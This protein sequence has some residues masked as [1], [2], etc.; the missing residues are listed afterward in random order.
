MLLSLKLENLILIEKAVVRFEDGFHIITGETGS[1][2]SILLTAIRLILG[3]KGG[4]DLIRSQ[5]P[6][7]IIEAEFSSFPNPMPEGIDAPRPG[8]PLLIRREILPSG[9]SRCFVQDQLVSIAI[10]RKITESL[11]EIVDQSSSHLLVSSESQRLMLDTFANLREQASFFA[12]SFAEEKRLRKQLENALLAN[13]NQ[14]RDLE[15]AESGLQY[16]ENVQWK[17]DEELLLEEQHRLLA[18]AQELIEKTAQVADGLS[19]LAPQMKQ[20]NHILETAAK[21]DPSLKEIAQSI[22]SSTI[23]LEEAESSL[24]AYLNR[25]ETA[26]EHLAAIESRLSLI[27]QIKRRFG[28]SWEAVEKQKGKFFRQIEELHALEGQIDTLKTALFDIEKTNQN[29]AEQ[30]SCQRQTAAQ[31]LSA[32]VLKELQDLNLPLAQFEIS[33]RRIEMT[34]GG[35]DLV[36]FLFSANPGLSPVPL[37]QAAS[38]GELSRLVLALKTALAEQNDC[39]CLI[40]DEIDSNVGGQTAVALGEK[41]RAIAKN[42]QVIAVTHFVQVAKAALHHFSV[43][44]VEKN[45]SFITKVERLSKALREKEYARMLG[46]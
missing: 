23:E 44:K 31:I 19:T 6:C 33:V 8:D 22:K 42:A 28:N 11:V 34:F 37:E 9:K 29:L 43:C 36:R 41:L 1:G 30:I 40:F 46:D 15:W 18:N 7:A 25:K 13:A 39:K 20:L 14:S 35:I 38:G 16:I 17:K 21:I 27:D 26:P 3:E 24:Q 5:A 10:L 45:G 32:Q 2:K 12:N 4:A